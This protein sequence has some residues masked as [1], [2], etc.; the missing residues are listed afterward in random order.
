M[1]ILV[2]GSKR[3]EVREIPPRATPEAPSLT[4]HPNFRRIDDATNRHQTPH[5]SN[6]GHQRSTEFSFFFFFAYPVSDWESDTA[7]M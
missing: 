2:D 7:V 1:L 6:Y 3:L 4:A 5:A